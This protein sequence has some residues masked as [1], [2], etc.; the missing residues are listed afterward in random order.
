MVGMVVEWIDGWSYYLRGDDSG[1]LE[2]E[3][4]QVAEIV[5]CSMRLPLCIFHTYVGPWYGMG[6]WK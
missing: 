4:E 5:D 6:M 2:L 3:G 1:M